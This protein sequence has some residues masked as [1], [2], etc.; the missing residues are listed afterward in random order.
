[1]SYSHK[2]TSQ[3]NDAIQRYTRYLNGPGRAM[4]DNL[5]EGDSFVMET[6]QHKIKVT[7][8]LGK[9]VVQILPLET[10]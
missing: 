10:D 8:H 1:M 3:E 2:K 6:E 9:A 7:K 4:L 5:E